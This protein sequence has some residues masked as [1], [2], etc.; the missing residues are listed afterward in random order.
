MTTN[1]LQ[2]L[3]NA[4][5]DEDEDEEGEG[6]PTRPMLEE[7]YDNEED[8]ED[9]EDVDGNGSVKR[10]RKMKRISQPFTAD[11]RSYHIKTEN[12]EQSER[13]KYRTNGQEK[14]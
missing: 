12:R 1:H 13:C 2:A 4:K 8:E 3:E 5:E 9:E 10:V 6:C 11:N 7:D 14:R